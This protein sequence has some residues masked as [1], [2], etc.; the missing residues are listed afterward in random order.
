MLPELALYVLA[1]TR[2]AH[3]K[4]GL[5]GK[6]V[7]LWSRA[8]RCKAAWNEHERHCHA[9]VMRSVEGLKSRR[10][11]AVLG[12]GLIR[13]VPLAAL[14]AHF[15]RVLL[16]DAVHLLPARMK[17]R[18]FAN[19]RLVTAD[20]SGMVDWMT[21]IA[22]QPA[23]PFACLWDETGLDLVISANILSQIPIGLGDWLEKHPERAQ[24]LGPDFLSQS[25]STHLAALYAL[26]CRSCLLTDIWYEERAPDKGA[27]KRHDLLH[28]IVLPKTDETWDWPVAPLG[29]ESPDY[30]RIHRVAAFIR[31]PPV[32]MESI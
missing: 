15:E 27:L 6:A 18:R 23:V 25:V 10:T 24:A 9:A 29:E 31:S 3:R 7:S 26:P 14:A 8:F 11:V 20:L 16:V 4:I 5:L 30:A 22:P 2:R 21:G 19:V 13:D 12:S 32:Q 1:S 28:G 17:A